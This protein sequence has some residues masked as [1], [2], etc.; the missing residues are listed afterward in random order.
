MNYEEYL[1]QNPKAR[2]IA[3]CMMDSM[4]KQA[5]MEKQA[6][7]IGALLGRAAGAVNS[8]ATRASKA[9]HAGLNSADN[10]GRLLR[11]KLQ[12]AGGRIKDAYNKG[13]HKYDNVI[14]DTFNPKSNIPKI[15]ESLNRASGRFSAL[16][17]VGREFGNAGRMVGRGIAN[18]PTAKA[19]L[20]GT[21]LA[22]GAAGLQ[23]AYDQNKQASAQVP[24]AMR[25]MA[26]I[27]D[28]DAE[29]I[30]K[31]AACCKKNGKCTKVDHK[32]MPAGK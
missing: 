3:R 22:L 10:L 16:G 32:Q 14:I 9:M 11:G 26:H 25:L 29:W 19:T 1:K 23:R 31:I 13:A 24:P 18:S 8:G 7:N 30:A 2:L 15:R 4:A 12:R 5:G 28:G 27:I 17:Q 20:A 21:G 6:L